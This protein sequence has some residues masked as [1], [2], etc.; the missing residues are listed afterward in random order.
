MLWVGVVV[1]EFL[2]L[3]VRCGVELVCELESCLVW[4]A[5][6]S[7]GVRRDSNFILLSVYPIPSL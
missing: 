5:I 3:E 1:E 2:E 7:A 6:I 4:R